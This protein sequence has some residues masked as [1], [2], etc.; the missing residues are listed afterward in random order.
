MPTTPN[1]LDVV[2]VIKQE[3]PDLGGEP[4]PLIPYPQPIEPLEDGIEAAALFVVE[5]GRR[6]KGVA[7]WSDNG[8]IRFRDIINPGTSGTGYTLTELLAGAGGITKGLHPA[9]LQLIHFIDE[10]PAEGF[11]SG[12]TK[13]VSGPK[14]FPTQ[15]LWKRQDGTSLVERNMIWTGINVTTNEWKIYAADG[16]T[17]LVSV[18]DTITYDGI[19][20]TGRTRAIW[21]A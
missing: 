19:F 20:E 10:G 16:S 9:L 14:M 15:W 17:L 11:V 5:V 4:G 8:N 1:D 13:T 2:Q 21:E 12:A 3:W 6:N 7:I 18:T